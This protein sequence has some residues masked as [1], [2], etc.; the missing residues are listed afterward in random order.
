MLV[1]HASGHI[2]EK[3]ENKQLIFDSTDGNKD[4]RKKY[5]QFW[6]GIK[7]KIEAVSSG[8]CYYEKDYMKNKFN[9]DA[10]PLNIP[11]KFHAISI[12]TRSFFEK[13]GKLYP[14]FFELIL[15]MN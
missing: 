15:C 11:L 12:V 4:L 5:S 9:S 1:N 8:E 14:Q 3:N 10:L 6:N 2:E 13:D 7:N